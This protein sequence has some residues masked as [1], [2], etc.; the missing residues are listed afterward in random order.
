MNSIDKLT[1]AVGLRLFTDRYG[2]FWNL[3]MAAT[4][5]MALPPILLFISAQ[6]YFVKGVV[7]TGIAGR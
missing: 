1:L 2:G 6:R 7:M 4:A 3:Q 5:V